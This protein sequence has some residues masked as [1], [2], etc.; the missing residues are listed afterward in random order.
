MQIIIDTDSV[1]VGG[2]DGTVRTFNLSALDSAIQQRRLRM[3]EGI[4][5]AQELLGKQREEA[6]S[7]KKKKKGGNKKKKKKTDA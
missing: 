7:R 4:Q 6:K 2:A 5:I 3:E 1:V